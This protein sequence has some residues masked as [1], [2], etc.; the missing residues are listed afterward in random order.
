MIPVYAY[1]VKCGWLLEPAGTENEKVIPE[2]YRLSV[3]EHLAT[4]LT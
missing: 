1:L 2:H 4:R 3:A